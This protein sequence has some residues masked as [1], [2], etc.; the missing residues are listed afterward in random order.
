MSLDVWCMPE[1]LHSSHMLQLLPAVWT[2]AHLSK[3]NL[4]VP[5]LKILKKTTSHCHLEILR[6]DG[7]H[8]G[9]QFTMVVHTQARTPETE[10]GGWQGEG[11]PG[12]HHIRNF[13]ERERQRQ[14]GSSIQCD[15]LWLPSDLVFL[16]LCPY[17]LFPHFSSTLLLKS[18]LKCFLQGLPKHHQLTKEQHPL[19]VSSLLS[20]FIFFLNSANTI[21]YTMLWMYLLVLS[22][23]R[24]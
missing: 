4:F 10:T 18:R 2:Q 16:L 17:S 7:T 9:K 6:Y 22:L 11:Y 14:R 1:R 24:I 21:E 15:F 13:Q 5:F 20:C 19:P 23:I 3:S 8:S 12:L